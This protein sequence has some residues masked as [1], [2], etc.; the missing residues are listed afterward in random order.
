MEKLYRL[1]PSR[2]RVMPAT[3]LNTLK[4]TILV[5]SR[6]I[7]TKLAFVVIVVKIRLIHLMLK[8]EMNDSHKLEKVLNLIYSE[9]KDH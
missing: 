1:I 2:L 7:V 5:N 6:K 9:K 8:M 4:R 3:K